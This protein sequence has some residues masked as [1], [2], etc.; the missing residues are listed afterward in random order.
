MVAFISSILYG[1]TTALLA[2][3]AMTFS[4]PANL[5]RRI[6]MWLSYLSAAAMP[7]YG[8]AYIVG[9]WS[10]TA[11]PRQAWYAGALSQLIVAVL[12]F[13][14][15]LLCAIATIAQTRGTD[16]ARLVW[17][18][19]ALGILYLSNAVIGLAVSFNAPI[20]FNV[21]LLLANVS[22]FLV[23][24]GLTYVVLSRRVLDIGFALNRALVF[25]AVSLI[26]L[27]GFFLVEWALGTWLSTASHA[28]NLVVGAAIALTLGFSVRSIHRRVDRVLDTIFFRKR[29]EDERAIREFGHEAAYITD[30]A[31]LLARTKTMLEEHADASSVAILL[32][33]GQGRL[34]EASENDPAIVSLRARRKAVDLHAVDTT[35]HG[36]F[37][38]PLIAR[39]HLVGAI[40]LGP[41]RSGDPYAPDESDAIMHLAHDVGGAIDVLSVNG[42]ASP[43]AVLEAIQTMSSDLKA[44]AAEIRALLHRPAL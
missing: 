21:E 24:V 11:D 6:L 31:V 25:S 10:A 4:T 13:L 3:Y 5:L 35:L 22:I 15:P 28:T 7:L 40:V 12:P 18:T 32:D 39:G 27:G 34:G 20:D 38:Y 2:T 43:D 1:V 9:A 37:A 16:R 26:F 17:A 36:E 19:A 42:R 30:A 33:D 8:L 23:P 29:H 44:L 41:K 14:F